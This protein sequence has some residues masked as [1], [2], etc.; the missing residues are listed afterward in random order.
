MISFFDLWVMPA[1]AGGLW[2]LLA[3]LVIHELLGLI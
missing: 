1:V 2:G 3:A